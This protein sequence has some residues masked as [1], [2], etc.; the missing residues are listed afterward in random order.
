MKTKQKIVGAFFLLFSTLS[1]SI[2]PS[3]PV[4]AP[5]G[6]IVLYED[7]IDPG[8]NL[9]WS[10][11]GLSSPVTSWVTQSTPG[12][13][14]GTYALKAQVG[15]S[16]GGG[17]EIHVANM[18]LSTSGYASLAFSFRKEMSANVQVGIRDANNSAFLPHYVPLSSYLV[19]NQSTPLENGKW[20]SFAIPLADM[21]A[22]YI[23]LGSVV[24]YTDVPGIMYVDNVALT[25]AFLKF[26]LDCSN[27]SCNGAVDYQAKGA[28]TAQ[29]IVSILDHKMTAPYIDKNGVIVSFT[30]ETFNTT[31][32]YPSGGTAACYP[33]AG[34]ATWSGILTDL[35]KGTEGSGSNNCTTGAA[36]NYEAHPGYDYKAEDNTPVRAAASGTVVNFGGQK[37]IPKMSL[38]ESCDAYGAIG[39]DHGNGYITQYLHMSSI[40][41]ATPGVTTVTQGQVIGLSGRTHGGDAPHLHFE[42]LK[43]NPGTDG[44]SRDHYKVVDP[45]GWS[46]SCKDDPLYQTTGVCNMRLWK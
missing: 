32:A 28:Y 40:N 10:W 1:Y 41:P 46:G 39:I 27:A 17:L 35:Y 43:R 23:S 26:P 38:T 18:T 12:G 30:N 8:W 4:N 6:P 7:A 2:G 29:G 14:G 13:Q 37:C 16:T 24:F 22:N 9:D 31:S 42:V 25:Y 44:T 5:E 20:Y 33:K 36:L 15:A 3:C 11:G 34:G 45:Y 19:P 21:N